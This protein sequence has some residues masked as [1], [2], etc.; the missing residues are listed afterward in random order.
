MRDHC[1]RLAISVVIV[2]ASGGI[3]SAQQGRSRAQSRAEMA[4]AAGGVATSFD[5]DGVPRFVVAT[6]SRSGPPDAT[7]EG[8]ARWHLDRFSRAHNVMPTDLAAAATV[9]EHTLNSGDVIVEMRQ[10]VAG[11]DVVGSDVKVLMRGDHRLVAISGRPRATTGADTRF[12]RSP[13][14][15]LAAALSDRFGMALGAASIA[16]VVTAGGEQHFRIS[17]GVA[18]FM[19]EAA[20]V[21]PVLFPVGG[22]LVAAYTTDFYAGQRNS[23]DS[24]AYRY[25]IAASDGRVLERRD[26]TVSEGRPGASATPPADFHYRVFADPADQRPL[27]GPEQALSPHPTGNPDGIFPPFV[28]PNLVTI[29]GFNH[30]VSGVPDP[31]LAP[32]A[33]ETTGNNAD[34]YVDLDDTQDGFTPGVDFRAD[35]TSTRS[36]DRVYDT[37]IAPVATIDQQ[38]AAIVNAFYTVNWLHDFW[39]DSGFDE[40]AGNAQLS[41]YGRG[42]AEG[43]PMRVEVQDNFLGGSRNNANMSTPADGIRPRMQMFTWTGPFTITLT[44]T[45]GGDKETNVAAF[46]PTNFDV[47]APVALAN[48]GVGVATDACEPLSGLTGRIV[49]VDRGVCTFVVKAHNVQAAGGLGIIIANNVPGPAPGLGGADPTITIAVM[50]LSQADG[51]AVKAS[52]AAGPVTAHM[53]RFTGVE[54]DGAVD[55]TIVGHEW[56][57][58]LHH[59]LADC[60][61]PQCSAM[62]EGWGDFIALH[63]ILRDGDN[64][65]GVFP[66]A[67]YATSGFGPA[68]AYFGIR[69]VPY[70]V[71]FT[72]NAYTLKHITDG[73][74]LPAVPTMAFGPNSEVHNAGEIWATML[75]EGYVALQKAR[76]A[77]K[78]FDE[79]RR[80]MADYVVAGLK[81]TP[82]DA[83]YI[84]QRDAILAAAASSDDGHGHGRRERDGGPSDQ[85]TLAQAFAR[86]GAG[87]CAVAPPRNSLNFAGV[88]E[89]FEVRPRIAIGEIRI[90]EDHS[91]DRDGFIDAGERGHI[92][93]PVIN[94]GAVAMLNT[95]VTLSTS[96][97]GVSIKKG[98]ARVARIAPLSSAEVEFEIEVDRSFTGIGQLALTATVSSDAA[99][100][101]SVDRSAFARIN[102]DEVLGASKIDN[103]ETHSTPWTTSG[104]NADDIWSR[105]DVAPFD[106]AWFG[107]DVPAVSDTALESPALQVGT[108]EPFVISFDHRFGFETNGG[109][110]PF[111]DG[112]VLEISRNGG[113]FED[114]AAFVDPGYGGTIFVGSGNPLAGRPALVGRNASFPAR[115]TVSLNLG[116]Q[117][118]GQTV[119]IRFRIGTDEASSDIGWE[120]DNLAF[121]GITNSPFPTFIPDQ[122]RCRGIPKKSE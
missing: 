69:R 27:D 19:S 83:T 42:G 112:G 79:V 36:F 120:L 91:C 4:A 73:V 1:R 80:R 70:S 49:L 22:A 104:A 59:R 103:V 65:N 110:A 117:F 56:G 95:T 67:T 71:D 50:S 122:A 86:R 6:D 18:V 8:A 47:T 119:K 118:A 109:V 98:S 30:P 107:V 20:P 76:S 16:S 12:V 102:V 100:E 10:R 108:T 87:S 48:D 24:A 41:N 45:P 78:T 58:Y 72:K 90:E 121:Q 55:N 82:P 66:L 75:W 35:L 17:D 14:D 51:V 3:V 28:G 64:L 77:D 23:G 115:D 68:S 25:V 11:L 94:G 114:I 15:A 60:G 33:I 34:A 81:M 26:L 93:V 13:E 54:R 96:T 31:W 9:G 106:R 85:L 37:T 57:H 74:P 21:R 88:V 97:S 43:D 61:V 84:E 2:L 53:F 63:T 32:D 38:K 99:C 101:P 29:A 105:I 44:F 92:T 89:S 7:H 39:Y 5:S 40:I 111:F 116:M 46:G 52:I 113:A 62:S